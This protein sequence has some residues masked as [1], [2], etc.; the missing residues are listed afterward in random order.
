LKELERGGF[1]GLK[2][3]QTEREEGKMARFA[4]LAVA[5]LAVFGSVCGIVRAD[6]AVVSEAGQRS[7]FSCF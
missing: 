1:C 6:D 4:A 3:L 7:G 5:L 2:G